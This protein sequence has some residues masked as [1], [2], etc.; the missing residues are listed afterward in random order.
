MASHFL[1]GM[2]DAP[3]LLVE[4]GIESGKKIN[5]DLINNDVKAAKNYVYGLTLGALITGSTIVLLIYSASR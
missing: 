2:V 1:E 3:K 4:K 5:Q